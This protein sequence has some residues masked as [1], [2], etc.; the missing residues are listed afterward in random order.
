VFGRRP[1]RIQLLYL[2]DGVSII[3]TPSEQSIRGLERRVAAVWQAVERACAADDFRPQ[4]GPLCSWC[5][6]QAF[7]PA[8]GGDPATAR[9]ELVGAR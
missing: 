8:Y 5:S 9:Q 7:C 3:A 6:F 1:A 4:V 2:A